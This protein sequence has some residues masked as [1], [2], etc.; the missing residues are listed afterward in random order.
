MA[1]TPPSEKARPLMGSVADLL[2][3]AQPVVWLDSCDY[4]ARLLAGGHAPWLDPA[5]F[6]AWQRKTQGLLKSDVAALPLAPAVDAWL[7]AHAE[8]R[9]AM[10]ARTRAT[11][12]LKTLLADDALRAHLVDLAR[13]LRA[14]LRG[15]P[16]ALVVPSPRA[17]V[18]LS[19]RQAHSASL[20]VS[21]DEAD[22][23]AVYVADF[24]RAFGDVGIDALLLEEAPEFAPAAASELACYQPVLN[25]AAHYRWDAG[26]HL[27]QA[28]RFSG[29][30]PGYGFVIASPALAGTACAWSAPPDSFNGAGPAE[31][32]SS[33]RYARIPRD[34]QPEAVLQRLAALR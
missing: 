13:G 5:A 33:F 29:P 1:V 31:P 11:Y 9:P 25:V 8:L 4:S 14:G 27:A 12:A 19:Y 22:T 34:A 24:L 2:K 10:A 6:V 16:L 15:M 7:D 30:L 23:A 17:W 18:E 3:R 32:S 28:G 21:A 20:E 26:L